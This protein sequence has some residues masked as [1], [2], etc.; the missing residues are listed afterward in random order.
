VFKKLL[1]LII[2]AF[3]DMVGLLM[4]LP[5]MPFY[6]RS[7]GA[8]ALMVT[9][10]IISFTAAQLVSAPMWGRFS[11]RYGRRPAL[12]VGLGAAAIAYVVFALANSLWLL[13]LSRMV[14]GAGG[15]TVGVI[16]A[17]VADTTEPKNRA[18]ALG[19]LSA[20][21]NVGVALGPPLGSLALLMG[22]R[23][24]GL[25][26]AGLC[27]TNMI[28]AWNFLSESREVHPAHSHEKKPSASRKALAYVITHAKEPGPRLIW[29]YAIAMGAFSGM[30]AILALF[31]MDRWGI[32][33]RRIWIFFTYIGTISVVT[34]AGV[35]GWAVD[36]F[37]EARLSRIGLVLL[38]TGLIA[39]PFV[40]NYVLLAI[41]IACIPLGTAFT[42]PCV[43]SLL[44]RVIEP[45]ER[46]LYMGVQQA[47]GGIARVIVPLWAG[48]SYDHFGKTVPFLT[49]AAL[50]IGTIFLN[51]GIDDGR[52]VKATPEVASEA[53]V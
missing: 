10:L 1:I 32:T 8:S 2:T 27:I 16:Q 43:T 15:G 4:I 48:F 14:Q 22:P 11:D 31:L 7:L 9:I 6:A 53:A 35:L 24:P 34:R 13:L 23:G 29:I 28:F 40:R 41:F 50:V 19:W 33:E 45:H 44:S 39:F 12:L 42:F 37:G 3:V 36:R 25:V 26:A 17:Y 46:G 5:L 49:S 52:K 20:A 47:Y 21:T 51:L 30:S 38:S 18:R